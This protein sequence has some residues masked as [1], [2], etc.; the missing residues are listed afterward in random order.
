M[1]AYVVVD[2]EVTD[3]EGYKEYVKVAP[4][5]VDPAAA[6]ANTILKVRRDRICAEWLACQSSTTITDSAGKPRELCYSLGRC[7]EASGSKSAGSCGNW[8]DPPLRQQHPLDEADYV[9][10]NITW[11]GQD[12]SGYSIPGLCS[13]DAVNSSPA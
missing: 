2:I 4:Q 11:A 3:P 10:R 12:Y 7:D 9:G 13:L 1:S 8:L 5:T 6:D